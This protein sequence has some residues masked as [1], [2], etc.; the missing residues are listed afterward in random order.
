M[1]FRVTPQAIAEPALAAMRHWADSSL[2]VGQSPLT[3][4]FGE[5]RGF[6]ITFRRDG[7]PEIERRFPVLWPYFELIHRRAHMLATPF[8]RLALRLTRRTSEAFFFNL[9]AVPSGAAVGRH[10]DATLDWVSGVPGT[11]PRLVTVLYL[12]APP[13]GRLKL[14]RDDIEVASIEP[15]PGTLVCFRGD[16]AHAVETN[17]GADATRVSLVCEHYAFTPAQTAQMDAM[18]VRSRGLFARV[19]AKVRDQSA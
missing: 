15:T 17:T 10:V 9:L 18:R 2:H 13:G 19:L 12:N 16:L 7:L 3:G 14:W 8:E 11:T 6:A 1:L 5:S 4:T